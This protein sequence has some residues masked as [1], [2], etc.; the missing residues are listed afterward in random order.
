MHETI[1]SAVTERPR[2]ASQY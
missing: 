1:S 2:D